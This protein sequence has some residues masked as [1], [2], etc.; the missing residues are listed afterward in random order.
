MDKIEERVWEKSRQLHLDAHQR[1][2]YRAMLK[3]E[4]RE[5]ERWGELSSRD[6]VA[7]DEGMS[8]QDN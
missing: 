2:V 5:E 1:E 6:Y 4:A 8:W 3:R 7:S